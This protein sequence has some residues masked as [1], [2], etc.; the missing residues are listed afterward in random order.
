M[1]THAACQSCCGPSLR[2]RG[3]LTALRGGPACRSLMQRQLALGTATVYQTTGPSWHQPPAL[4]SSPTSLPAAAASV[5]SPRAVYQV[6]APHPACPLHNDHTAWAA[7]Q[8]WQARVTNPQL[9]PETLISLSPVC[10]GGTATIP[11]WFIPSVLLDLI[12]RSEPSIIH[13][14]HSKT[15]LHSKKRAPSSP[16]MP[17]SLSHALTVGRLTLRRGSIITPLTPLIVGAPCM[18][19]RC[20]GPELH[21]LHV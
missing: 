12:Q 14:I 2:P 15:W 8:R 7:P 13:W 1:V 9:I 4:P 3:S 16:C 6:S 21:A 10:G 5:A 18:L 19:S 11:N 17:V 20:Q